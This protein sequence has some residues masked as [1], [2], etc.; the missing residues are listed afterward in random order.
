MTS[1]KLAQQLDLAEI[2]LRHKVLAHDTLQA[3][4]PAAGELLIDQDSWALVIGD[5][6]T[7]GG[8]P[9]KLDL[10]LSTDSTIQ[11]LKKS[12][13]DLSTDL[14]TLSQK[15]TTNTESIAG[16]INISGERGVLKGYETTSTK[17][18]NLT[19]GI[20]S[21]DV[22]ELSTTGAVTL[23]FTP[24][25]AGQTSTKIVRLTATG[26]TTLT[27]SGATWANAGSAPTWGTSGKHLT[28]VAHYIGAAVI[29]NVFDNDQS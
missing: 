15:V 25:S 28:L 3:M 26:T 6:T 18:G 12:V 21:E 1:I 9:L 20:D 19:I 22:T 5:G 29:L 8:R 14:G 27:I 17:S 10:D 2:T 13:S 16:K 23:T 4:T 7:A 11:G 24:G